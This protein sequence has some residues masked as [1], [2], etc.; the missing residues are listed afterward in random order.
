MEETESAAP[1]P[2]LIGNVRSLFLLNVA[3]GTAAVFVT[4]FPILGMLVPVLN[5]WNFFA[6]GWWCLQFDAHR[7]RAWTCFWMFLGAG[8]CVILL[9]A[10]ASVLLMVILVPP[11]PGNA[12][13]DLTGAMW[14]LLFFLTAAA[15]FGWMGIFAGHSSG[16]KVWISVEPFTDISLLDR[17]ARLKE[18]SKGAFNYG[19]IVLAA[20]VSVILLPLGAVLLIAAG[21]ADIPE[22]ARIAT[23]TFA[24]AVLLT[25]PIAVILLGCRLLTGAT[26]HCWKNGIRLRQW[27]TFS[28]EIN[29]DGPL[30]ET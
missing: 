25:V 10:V 27:D 15:A 23:A 9:G 16:T 24:F 5:G 20:A 4:G 22:V 6:C 29:A 18:P 1:K 26:E 21:V 2:F 11:N 14:V 13:K 7:K 12:V 30:H 3:A 28:P 8:C 17:T 19:P